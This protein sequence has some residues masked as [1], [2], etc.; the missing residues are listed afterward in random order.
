MRFNIDTQKTM[1]WK[2]KHGSSAELVALDSENDKRTRIIEPMSTNLNE[3]ATIA[4][5]HHDIS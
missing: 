5:K 2:E 1:S 4:V 3:T